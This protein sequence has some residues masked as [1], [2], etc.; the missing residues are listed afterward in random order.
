MALSYGWVAFP[1]VTPRSRLALVL[2][3]AAVLIGGFFIARGSGDDDTST[4]GSTVTTTAAPTATTAPAEATTT[5]ATTTT[6]AAPAVP[7]IVISGGKPADGVQKLEVKKGDDVRFK[8]RSDVSD[9]IHVHGYDIHKDVK[10]GGS[11]SFDFPATIDGKFEIELEA[12]GEQ[13]A[14]LSVE[15]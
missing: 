7:T 13:I 14:S 11:V 15:P 5:A 12:A 3:A 2:A 4:T 6:P 9:E 1:C 8:V 10:A